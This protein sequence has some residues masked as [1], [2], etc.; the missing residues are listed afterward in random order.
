M[1]LAP[2]GY[3]VAVVGASSLLGKEVLTVLEERGFPVSRLIKLESDEEEPD[4]PIVDLNK[5]FESAMRNEEVHGQDVDF[6]FLVAQPQ[7]G[8]TLPAFLRTVLSSAVAGAPAAAA[9]ATAG[10]GNTGGPSVPAEATRGVVIDLTDARACAQG[11]GSAGVLSVP[12]LDRRTHRGHASHRAVPGTRLIVSPHPAAILISSLVLR[13]A[14]RFPLER[15]VANVFGPVSEIGPKGI[16]ELQKQTVNLLSFQ[17]IPR[18]VFGAQL[19]FNLLPRLGSTQGSA[20]AEL[21]TRIRQQLREFLSGGAPLPSV[22]IFQ[23]PV[24]YSLALS[25]YVE[26]AAPSAPEALAQALEGKPVR[27]RRFSEGAP[28]QVEAV[29]SGDILVDAI[30]ADPNHPCGAWLWAVADNLRLAA[31]NAV[32][33]AESLRPSK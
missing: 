12:F 19:A 28:L 22:R 13:L 6:T 26:T 9:A 5:D 20:L 31:V 21:E 29:G 10:A 24:F 25:L 16:E 27:L 2:Q 3:R 1:K 30:A 18:S 14:S 7:G 8:A 32:E 33:I 4:A 23:A 17:K 11:A 15:A